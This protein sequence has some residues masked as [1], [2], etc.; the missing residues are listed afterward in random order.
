MLKPQKT[1]LPDAPVVVP[2]QIVDSQPV[3]EARI[4]G[5]GPYKFLIDTGAAGFGRIGNDLAEQL[6][7]K[8]VGEVTAGDP[9]GQHEETLK[10]VGVD[11]ISVGG[12][13]F[14]GG[15][16]FL[17]RDDKKA[18]VEERGGIVGIL[19]LGVFHDSLF[20]L[21]YPNRKVI[22][23]R[24]SLSKAD[25]KS[26]IDF[27]S[28]HGIPEIMIQ[29]AGIDVE[30]D[31]DSGSMGGIS[32]PPSVADKLHFSNKPTV[33]GRASTGFNQFDIK[34]AKLD[35]DVRIG[36]NVIAS[37][38][39]SIIDIFPRANIGGRI[40]QSFSVTVDSVNQRIRF[41]RD[42]D[43][44][45]VMAPKVRVGVLMHPSD[46]GMKVDHVVPGSPA[47]SAHIQADDIITQVN[48]A[49]YKEVG[50]EKLRELF[51][52]TTPVKLGIDRAGKH[53]DVTVTP[54]SE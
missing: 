11:S 50:P 41:S 47:E 9:S 48:G 5:Q 4:N 40:L 18:N 20:T 7:L 34:E 3:V 52:A 31:L 54:R 2:M 10:L 19:G 16:Q 12:A 25:G 22:I 39:L 51:A 36:G 1:E 30:T 43:G 42:G 6:K 53:I 13:T 38:M 35:G 49:A 27:A 28:P 32:V 21:D 45:I 33:V 23:E 17:R 15:L 37:P 46:E 26:E 24:G 8:E 44:P 14:S 29:V